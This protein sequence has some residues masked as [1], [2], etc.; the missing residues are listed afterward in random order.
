MEITIEQIQKK[1]KS[2]PEEL[3]WA[4]IDSNIDDKIIAI[5]ETVGLN[6]E[7]MGQ[8]SLEVY[9]VLIGLIHPDD[10]ASSIK[11]SLNVDDN[12]IKSIVDLTNEK[13]FK[14][15][16]EKILSLHTTSTKKVIE[17]ETE[18]PQKKEEERELVTEDTAKEE[19]KPVV[20]TVFN[21]VK[22]EENL[23]VEES[24]KETEKKFDIFSDKMSGVFTL[25]PKET[26]HTEKDTKVDPYR[27]NPNE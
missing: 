5:G 7:K 9:V 4:I 2:L 21:D 27:L 16:R 25:A 26:N 1:F 18:Q 20:E 22:K 6:I 24:K 23:I 12:R 19:I 13:I 14:N 15:I 10:F 8:L 3:R 11:K 17:I